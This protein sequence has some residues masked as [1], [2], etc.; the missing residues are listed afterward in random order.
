MS[1]SMYYKDSDTT[2]VDIREEMG[3][4][5]DELEDLAG[6]EEEGGLL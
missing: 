6:E 3:W 2:I 4:E 5:S 1:S